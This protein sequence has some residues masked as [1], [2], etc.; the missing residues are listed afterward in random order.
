MKCSNQAKACRLKAYEHTLK[1]MALKLRT[2]PLNTDEMIDNYAESIGV[3]PTIVSSNDQVAAIRQQR[4]EQQQ[5]MQ[6]MQMAQ[7]AV[8]GAQALGNTPMDDNSAL[9]AL[10]GGGQ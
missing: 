5:Q 9:A 7:E 3:S 6:Q 4:A 8:A 2:T 10:A 1:A